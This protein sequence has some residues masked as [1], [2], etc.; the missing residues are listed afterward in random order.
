VTSTPQRFG[1]YELLERLGAGGM[2]DVW[3]ATRDGRVVVIKRMRTSLHGDASAASQFASEA[4]IARRLRHPNLVEVFDAGVVEDEPYLVLEHVDGADLRRVLPE[5]QRLTSAAAVAVALD[6][7]RALVVVHEA[8][9][10]AGAPLGLVHRDVSAA[11]VMVTREGVAKLFDFGIA[12]GADDT[13][14]TRTGAF[15]GKVAYAAPEVLG[16]APGDARADLFSLGVLLHEALTG[17]R[18]FAGVTEVQTW[19]RVLAC[20]VPPLHT[21]VPD[22]PPELE[23]ACLQLLARLPAERTESAR[24]L[25]SALERLEPLVAQGRQEL[26]ALVAARVAPRAPVPRSPQR[27]RRGVV[28]GALLAVAGVA[29]LGAVAA[30]DRAA[31]SRAAGSNGPDSK[32]AGATEAGAGSDGAG[33]KRVGAT[34][35]AGLDGADSKRVGA[36]ETGAGS[37]G[38]DSKRA[39]ATEKA[40]LDGADLKQVGATETDSKRVETDKSAARRDGGVAPPLPSRITSRPA[41]A[42]VRT[43]DGRLLG[44]TPLT[45]KWGS[46]PPKQVVL[47]RLGFE[48]R[49]VVL[50]RSSEPLEVVLVPVAKSPQ[51]KSSGLRDGGVLDPFR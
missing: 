44:V 20:E 26:G 18:L 27:A 12:R 50:P 33:S 17:A 41:G 35:K 23:A 2:A 5:G 16:G 31:E 42:K 14:R 10:D 48:R 4:R 40:G 37:D 46:S 43:P 7:A 29:V 45:P 32:R 1:P 38:A 36:T 34:E 15:V 9:D 24:Q 22:V 8:C 49:V 21:A 39:G 25:V 11:N 19:A 30:A 13:R 6:L 51:S 3:R 47:E 28:I